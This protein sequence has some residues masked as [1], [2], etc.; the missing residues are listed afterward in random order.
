MKIQFIESEQ[1]GNLVI[2]NSTLKISNM[3]QNVNEVCPIMVRIIERALQRLGFE[4]SRP[5]NVED[6]D[7][8]LFFLL[9]CLFAI[10]AEKEAQ[11]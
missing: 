7:R 11:N 1:I 10:E 9:D 3:D 6:Y 2:A 5:D 4:V 8:Y